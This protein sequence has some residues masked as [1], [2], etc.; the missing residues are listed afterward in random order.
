MTEP[1]NGAGVWKAATLILA[2]IVISLL[3]CIYTQ[4]QNRATKSDLVPIAENVATTQAQ[5]QTMSQQ[6]NYLEGQLRAK[7]MIEK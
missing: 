7:K 6:F 1:Q 5:V 4:D 3:G 2:G